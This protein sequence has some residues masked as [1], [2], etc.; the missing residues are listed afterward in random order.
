MEKKKDCDQRNGTA[1]PFIAQEQAPAVE[2]SILAR[3]IPFGAIKTDFPLLLPLAHEILSALPAQRLFFALDGA[4]K[5]DTGLSVRVQV[6]GKRRLLGRGSGQTYK[7]DKVGVLSER[8][9]RI[10]SVLSNL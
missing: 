8:R 1:M 3:K 4:I 2:P 6:A 10:P 5:R 7:A 9:H